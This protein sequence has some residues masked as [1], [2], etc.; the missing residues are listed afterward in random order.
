MKI[1]PEALQFNRD[2]VQPLYLNIEFKADKPQFSFEPVADVLRCDQ[3]DSG[4]T[5]DIPSI[6]L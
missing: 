2:V 5:F 4:W 1:S 3:S 6:E